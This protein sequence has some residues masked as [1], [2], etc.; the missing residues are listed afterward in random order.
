MTL[1]MALQ[2]GAV[3][4]AVS[5]DTEASKVADPDKLRISGE[6][7]ARMRSA[8]KDVLGKLE[9]AR[10]TKDVVKLTCVNEKLTQIKGLL[11]ISETADVN[12]QESVA[13]K[14]TATSEHEY[15]KVSIAQSKVQQL[16][17]EA[18]QCMG[19]LAFRVDENLNVEVETPEYLP[20][21]DPTLL[22]PPLTLVDVRP[23][24]ASPTAAP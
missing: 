22:P 15:T 10:A 14:E 2:A 12:L 19:Q 16:R 3:L 9:E 8:L 20:K 18:E 6:G 5:G 24:P 11:R 13:R 4:A 21:G 17:A 23:V 7:L 1:L